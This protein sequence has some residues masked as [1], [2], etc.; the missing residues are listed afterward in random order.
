MKGGSDRPT[1]DVFHAKSVSHSLS[2][3]YIHKSNTL[4]IFLLCACMCMYY[5]I[6]HNIV[7]IIYMCIMF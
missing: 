5:S 1:S 6:T 4:R 3:V 7:I 2:A